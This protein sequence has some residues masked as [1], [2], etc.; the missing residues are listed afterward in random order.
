MSCVRD[1]ND[2]HIVVG[3]MMYALKAMR[4]SLLHEATE[5]LVLTVQV[6]EPTGLEGFNGGGVGAGMAGIVPQGTGA[7]ASSSSGTSAGVEVNEDYGGV[8]RAITDILMKVS[9]N[10]LD[11]LFQVLEF[12]AKVLAINNSRHGSAHDAQAGLDGLVSAIAPFLYRP[13]ETAHMSLRH[14]NHLT[15]VRP[16]FSFI[17]QH[18]HDICLLCNNPHAAAAAAASGSGGKLLGKAGV[19]NLAAASASSQVL[20]RSTLPYNSSEQSLLKIRSREE[21][22]GDEYDNSLSTFRANGSDS[23]PKTSTGR[24]SKKPKINNNKYASGSSSG[25]DLSPSRASAAGQNTGLLGGGSSEQ[26]KSHSNH[27]SSNSM[28]VDGE[29]PLNS[30][31][32]LAGGIGAGD[33][34][35]AGA[36]AYAK[37][38]ANFNANNAS[39]STQF[40]GWEWQVLESL[41]RSRVQSFC[42]GDFNLLQ[43][44]KSVSPYG[45]DKDSKY[46]SQTSASRNTSSGSGRD[47][48][49][50]PST[51]FAWGGGGAGVGAARA[52]ENGGANTPDAR[53]HL[54]SAAAAGTIPT[55]STGTVSVS[56][57]DSIIVTPSGSLTSSSKRSASRIAR[58]KA[59]AECRSLKQRIAAFEAQAEKDQRD[60]GNGSGSGNTRVGRSSGRS[61][62]SSSKGVRSA[63][64]Q[65]VL[66]RYKELKRNIRDN[67]ATDIQ[68]IMRGA[69]I[70]KRLHTFANA[71]HTDTDTDT[72][73]ISHSAIYTHGSSSSNNNSVNGGALGGGGGTGSG[74][75]SAGS[76]VD[77]SSSINLSGSTIMNSS[78]A[79][80]VAG[81]SSNETAMTVSM[82]VNN[83]TSS[84]VMDDVLRASRDRDRDRNSSIGASSA[85][86]ANN[87]TA[88][89]GNSGNNATTVANNSVLSSL[90]FDAGL[91]MNQLHNVSQTK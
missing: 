79:S 21:S 10:R 56:V 16:V 20:L 90:Q 23:S 5:K 53:T 58:H 3:V 12:A 89:N 81:G 91:H 28:A 80:N 30:V 86:Q 88:A 49:T 38:N 43:P 29:V 35:G 48:S 37:N 1:E 60:S 22:G 15:L 40:V 36:D 33:G 6:A 34:D 25:G 9:Q 75:T 32:P 41:V 39:G 61:S 13:Y 72:D 78:N 74:K 26:N 70:R 77:M 11:A 8:K 18:F 42:T 2:P 85:N 7:G 71:M 57:S 64:M 24:I 65:E 52:Y 46:R 44:A 54:T 63:E 14:K 62:S 19:S 50:S 83:S 55:P 73:R 69:L 87:T 82:S 31:S 4:F 27:S 45:S 59:V 67:A 84:L 47:R 68:R 66:S 51:R 17:L 76:S